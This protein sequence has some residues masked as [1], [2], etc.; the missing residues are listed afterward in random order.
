VILR[1]ATVYGPGSTSVVGEMARALRG[2]HMMLVGRGRTIAGLCY[3]ENLVDAV[4]LA[5]SHA[6]ASGEAFNITDGL[7]TT[8]REFLDDLAAGLG[9]PPVRWSLPYPAA[10]GLGFGL[11]HG[12]RR[13]RRATGFGVA[14]LLSRQAVHVLGRPQDFS[15]RKAA[16]VLG[17]RPR[18]G[19][20][21]ALDATLAWLRGEYLPS[22]E[23]PAQT[24]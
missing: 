10:I 20:A 5:L 24:G 6:A 3:V 21:A 7:T 11:E 4:E 18:V 12:Y 17:W 2:R 14:P 16:E 1:P 22:M 15:N 9:C 23:R 8:W 19:Y 13:L